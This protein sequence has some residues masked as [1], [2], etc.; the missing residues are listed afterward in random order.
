MLINPS[1]LEF[2]E[3]KVITKRSILSATQRVFDPIGFSSPISLPPKILLWWGSWWERLIGVLKVIL[4]KV[5]GKASL[6]Y[7]ELTTTLCDAEAV[8]NSRPLTY[9][10]DDPDELKPLSPAMFLK[11]VNAVG[12][13]DFDMLYTEKLNKKMKYRQK[14]FSDLRNRFRSEYL[15]TQ[16]RKYGKKDSRKVDIGDIVLIEEDNLK[17]INWPLARVLVAI[18]L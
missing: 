3:P 7:E 16:V 9:V 10:A 2:Q 8:I 6:S 15:S 17:R 11:E 1:N 13:P 14:V 18:N 12:V 5:L 4:R